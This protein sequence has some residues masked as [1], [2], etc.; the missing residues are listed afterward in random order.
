M[1]TFFSRCAV[2]LAIPLAFAACSAAEDPLGASSANETSAT[3]PAS[4][5]GD[6]GPGP[7]TFDSHASTTHFR[8][9]W[10]A[11]QSS[12][13]EVTAVQERLEGTWDKLAE[14]VGSSRM[15]TAKVEV[16]LEGDG[17]REHQPPNFPHVGEHGRVHLFRYPGGVSGAYE[18]QLVHETIH[19]IRSLIGLHAQHE[20]DWDSGFG[21]VEEGFAEMLAREVEPAQPGF[22]VFGLDFDIAAASW[23]NSPNNIPMTMLMH[24]HELNQHC[25]KQAYPLRASFMKFLLETYGHDRVLELGYPRGPVD[26]ALYSTLF[27]KTPDELVAAWKPWALAR[28]A[29][30]ADA[31][32]ATAAYLDSPMKFFP[33]CEAGTDF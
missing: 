26:D 11:S 28:L 32:Q 13:Q 24:R 21:F 14:W 29:R 20:A 8:L 23:L 7:D 18:R 1:L 19:S 22:P 12:P 6:D 4:S 27:G 2:V 30:H 33:L 25:M 31:A 16:Q 3:P 15:P 5:D 9:S 17:M 10:N